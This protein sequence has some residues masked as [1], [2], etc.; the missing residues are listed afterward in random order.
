M[1]KA[2]ATALLC[3]AAA[4]IKI[5]ELE[6]TSDKPTIGDICAFPEQVVMHALSELPA[7]SNEHKHLAA[8]AEFADGN[9]DT[10][11]VVRAF[12]KLQMIALPG[13]L[14]AAYK[15]DFKGD[16]TEDLKQ[17]AYAMTLVKG[18]YKMCHNE[19]KVFYNSDK[20]Q[21]WGEGIMKGAD[22]LVTAFPH[23]AG[24]VGEFKTAVEEGRLTDA[25]ESFVVGYG[26]D[27]MMAAAEK[28]SKGD[29]AKAAAA[30]W[31]FGLQ[32]EAE[33]YHFCALGG[34][35]GVPFKTIDISFLGLPAE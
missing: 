11:K 22:A 26:K 15:E 29:E 5:Q 31:V 9:K 20:C 19:G 32:K 3:G 10:K 34:W 23:K 7:G 2:I 14:T 1:F 4:A 30:A 24:I 6:F 25:T 18:A 17:L 13:A 16:K 33:M 28:A 12:D 8:F 27:V 35:G 21:A